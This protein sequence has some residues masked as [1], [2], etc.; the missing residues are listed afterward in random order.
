[1][2]L[3]DHVLQVH[4][5]RPVLFLDQLAHHAA[6]QQH[7]QPE[8]RH[9]L[10]RVLDI[11]HVDRGHLNLLEVFVVEYL[12][13]LVVFLKQLLG[14]GLAAEDRFSCVVDLIEEAFVLQ[15]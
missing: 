6:V 8:A 4:Q 1:M 2:Q 5:D 10:R 3:G 12:R 7:A 9:P 13:P 11:L 15:L 14:G